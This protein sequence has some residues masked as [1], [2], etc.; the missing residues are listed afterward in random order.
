MP[1]K[2]SKARNNG[3]KIVKLSVLGASLAGLAA[4][5]YFFLGPNGKKNQR[6]TKAWAVKMKAD[7]IEKLEAAREITEPVYHQII[8]SVSKEYAIGLKAGKEEVQAVAN[9]LKKHWKTISKSARSLK[10]V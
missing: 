1:K 4:T 8:D 10:R 9:D 2:I 5:A 6:H 7:V 3:S